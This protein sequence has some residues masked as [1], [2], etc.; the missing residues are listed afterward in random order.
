MMTGKGPVAPNPVHQLITHWDYVV[1]MVDLIIKET[2]LN[3]CA[4]QSSE[5]LGAF[6]LFDLSLVCLYHLYYAA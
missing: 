2:N 1:K 3:P 6:G 5:D 4:E